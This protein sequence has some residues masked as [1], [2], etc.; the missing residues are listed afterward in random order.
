MHPERQIKIKQMTFH[1]LL[2][3]HTTWQDLDG[4]ST[5]EH[6]RLNHNDSKPRIS[7]ELLIEELKRDSTVMSI[8]FYKLRCSS[9][10]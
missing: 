5:I 10:M 3:R 8:L 4:L 6:M 1:A 7:L 9:T 2:L